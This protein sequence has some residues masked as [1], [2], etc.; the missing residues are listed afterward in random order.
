M[1][2]ISFVCLQVSVDV[3]E[4]LSRLEVQS[5]PDFLVQLYEYDP[6]DDSREV[7]HEIGIH[8]QVYWSFDVVLYIIF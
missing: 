7:F 3:N 6:L 2:D 8:R 1:I 5:L 4:N